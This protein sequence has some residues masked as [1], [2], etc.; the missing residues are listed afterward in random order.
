MIPREK[1]PPL[2]LRGLARLIDFGVQTAVLEIAF[3]CAPLLPE[4]LLTLSED[5][6][7]Y[8]DIGTGIAALVLYTAISER[9]SGATLGKLLT[10]MR[11]VAEDGSPIGLRAALLRNLAFPIDALF[12][13]LIAYSAV[14][15][16]PTG[17]RVGDGWALVGD[18]AGFVDPMT[19]DGM[20]LALHG[21][22][23][24]AEVAL[25]MLMS[26]SLAGHLLLS[27]RR[28]EA[29]GRKLGVNRHL[30]TFV[31]HPALVGVGA[32]IAHAVPAVI[33]RLIAYA[34]DTALASADAWTLASPRA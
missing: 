29:F 19:G 12:F 7:L 32:G 8:V 11:V 23:L 25:E 26:P 30:R 9:L 15:R 34:G 1:I 6:L 13:G 27:G 24:A 28:A 5:N 18:A 22:K 14:A 10:G 31:D 4:S 2:L 17:Q 33:Q 3:R 21:G 16:S 20:R